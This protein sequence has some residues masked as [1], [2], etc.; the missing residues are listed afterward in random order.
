MN[1]KEIAEYAKSAARI[2][3]DFMITKICSGK[4]V[5]D[6]GCIGQDRNYNAENWLH[7]KLR[8]IALKADGVDILIDPIRELK[9]KGYSM[10]TI[11]ELQASGNMY[12]VLLMADV[13]EHVDDPVGFLKFY[14]TFLTNNGLIF[15]STPNANRA[16]NFIN[17]LFNNNYSVNPEH[18]CWFCP[19][20][21]AE[22]TE[23]AGLNIKEF[24]WGNQYYTAD[25][26]KG[27]YQ[28][29]KFKLSNLLI[30]W[31]SNFSPNMIFILSKQIK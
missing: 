7:N 22:V 6:V 4:N 14:S 12:D 16:N 26:V 25:S 23:R 30:S 2:E 15:I 21:F 10:F 1:K 18:T 9:R 20:T 3:K 5:L 8:K 27:A 29:F 19:K 28:K 17:I 13:I 31:R 11:E 24:Y